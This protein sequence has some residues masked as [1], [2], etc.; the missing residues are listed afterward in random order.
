MNTEIASGAHVLLTTQ[1]RDLLS[2]RKP[3]WLERRASRLKARH[4]V[5]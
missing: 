4:G 2:L 1:R 5:A 3:C